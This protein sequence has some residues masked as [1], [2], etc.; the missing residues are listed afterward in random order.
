MRGRRKIYIGRLLFGVLAVVSSFSSSQKTE[1]LNK[2]SATQ[3]SEAFLGKWEG[4]IEA[5]KIKLQFVFEIV[6]SPDNTLRCLY[7][8]PL[9]G[10]IGESVQSFSI[11]G[12]TINI[13][14]PLVLFTYSGSLKED[15][16]SIEGVLK[17]GESGPKLILKKVLNISSP[18]RPQTPQKPYPY[19]E[20]EVKF[21]NL[22]ED[23]V[24][25]GTLSYPR[26]GGPFPAAILI[27][28]AGPQDRNEEGFGGHRFF[29]VLA[30][31]LTRRGIAVLRYDDRGVGE[32]TGSLEKTTSAD[33]AEDVKGAFRFL[34]KCPLIDS[35]KIGLI[36][37]SEGGFIAQVVASEI[38]EIAW[39]VLMAGPAI[40]GKEIW[41]YQ[42]S[43]FSKQGVFMEDPAKYIERIIAVLDDEPND[44]RASEKIYSIFEEMKCPPEITKYIIDEIL[45]PW[46]R[47]FIREDPAAFLSKVKCPVLALGGNKDVHVPSSQNLKAVAEILQKAGNKNFKTIEFPKMNHLFQTAQTGLPTEYPL[48]DETMSTVVLNAIGDWI[49]KRTK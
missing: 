29:Q 22:H 27:S 48:I 4:F 23:A 9:Q 49:V 26:S 3:E 39:I 42:L 44:A 34:K 6:K 16:Q 15:H 11:E 25:A 33:L 40:S 32:S 1:P 35:Q 5:N 21:P 18:V 2:I 17:R 46:M 45:N 10:L 47:Y 8:M 19:V 41:L 37:H 31:D 13:T 14:I 20:Q 7:S 30:D 36:G 43:V 12:T 38:D 24:L 28:G